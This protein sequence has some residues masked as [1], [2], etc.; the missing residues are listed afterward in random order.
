MEEVEKVIKVKLSANIILYEFF[1][2]ILN[3]NGGVTV[4]MLVL[5]P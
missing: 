5:G 4:S 3:R 1:Q 2:C